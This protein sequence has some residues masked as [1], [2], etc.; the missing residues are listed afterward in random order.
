MAFFIQGPV[1]SSYGHKRAVWANLIA[2]DIA[3]GYHRNLTVRV[4]A[5]KI[6]VVKVKPCETHRIVKDAVNDFGVIEVFVK[7]AGFV[8]A[9]CNGVFAGRINADVRSGGHV[10]YR[11][12]RVDHRLRVFHDLVF[13]VGKKRTA[14]QLVYLIGEHAGSA[15]KTVTREFQGAQ[16]REH[17]GIVSEHERAAA[18]VQ[19][20]FDI[21]DAGAAALFRCQKPYDKAVG[22]FIAYRPLV[23][24]A[25]FNPHRN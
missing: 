12:G 1:P 5:V 10:E 15:E 22:P 13:N 14:G 20:P 16:A 24:H 9:A 11:R 4:A 7:D 21:F 23:V 6:F 3:Y 25:V 18:I 2:R 17:S 8:E 19:K